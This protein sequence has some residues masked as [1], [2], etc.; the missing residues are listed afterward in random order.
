MRKSGHQGSSEG[1]SGCS[2]SRVNDVRIK[3]E[4]IEEEEEEDEFNNFHENRV[5]SSLGSVGPNA[6]GSFS[7]HNI[8]HTNHYS[9]R[10]N[11]KRSISSISPSSYSTFN[12]SDVKRGIKKG[13]GMVSLQDMC[14]GYPLDSSP[15]LDS[16]S[17]LTPTDCLQQDMFCSRFVSN[18]FWNVSEEWS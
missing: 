8:N 15:P 18:N 10:I 3:K 7:H 4:V 17:P 16:S 9:S 14:S 12:Q 11:L 6:S 2:T 1:N 5:N 13:R